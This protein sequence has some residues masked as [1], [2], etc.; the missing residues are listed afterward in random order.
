MLICLL[1]AGGRF[2]TLICLRGLCAFAC[3]AAS[4]R[5]GGVVGLL[6]WLFVWGVAWCLF[7]LDV[8][9]C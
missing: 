8:Y 4:L 9:G 1:T 6:I 5:L 7:R 3:I 2:V